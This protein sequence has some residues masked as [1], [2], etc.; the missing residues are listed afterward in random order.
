[1]NAVLLRVLH[2]LGNGAVD[3][4]L[5]HGVLLGNGVGDEEAAA[6]PQLA[7]DVEGLG[8]LGGRVE[9][10]VDA[11]AGLAGIERGQLVRAVADDGDAVG[12]EVFEREAEVENGLRARADDHDGGVCQ[13]LKVGGDVEGLLRAAVHAADA[14]GGEH[15]NARHV[16]DHHRGGDGAR[17]VLALRDEHG[18]VAA[19][20]LGN[21]RAGAAEVVD[22]F[23]GKAG[24]EPSADDGDGG[25]HGARV[26]N[27]LLDLERGFNVLRVGHAVGND[28]GFERHDGLAGFE[29]LGDLGGDVQI[30]VHVKILL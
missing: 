29:R 19:G 10:V 14:A 22:L 16:G 24:F 2:G 28:G 13:L 23:L 15:A 9:L 25:G 21:A 3:D 12:L 6:Q 27:N 30:L 18:Q 8:K 7:L 20:G 1:M 5:V 26:A 4:C 11:K 17:A